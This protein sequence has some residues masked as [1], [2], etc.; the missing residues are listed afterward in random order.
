MR[1]QDC[2]RNT[3]VVLELASVL[4]FHK[5]DVGA[6]LPVHCAPLGRGEQSRVFLAAWLRCFCSCQVE[7]V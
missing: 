4:N 5:N 2:I 6:N 3:V 1:R 7:N